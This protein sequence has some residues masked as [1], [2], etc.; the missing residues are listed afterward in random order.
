MYFG[1]IEMAQWLKSLATLP[2][3]SGSG[4]SIAWEVKTNSNSS[5]RGSL[6]S[7]W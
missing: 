6:S 3:D 7:L 5:S 2:K 1:E 4:P